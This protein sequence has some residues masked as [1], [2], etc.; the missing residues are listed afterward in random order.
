[1]EIKIK[2]SLFVVLIVSLSLS[3]MGCES[4]NVNDRGKL[5]KS[6]TRSYEEETA[7]MMMF[8]P[9]DFKEFAPS[10]YRQVIQF[11]NNNKCVYSVL[12]PND[13]HF[14]A[15]GTWYFNETEKNI[16]IRNA[17]NEILYDY[18]VVI[19]EKNKLVVAN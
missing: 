12:A 13:A 9:S 10:R 16:E 18:K 19:L 6:W 4:E 7:G 1:M 2:T 3:K 17:E 14:M 5:M 8:R 11:E 15:A